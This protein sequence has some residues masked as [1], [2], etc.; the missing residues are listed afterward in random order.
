MAR[1]AHIGLRDGVAAG[2]VVAVIMTGVTSRAWAA[3]DVTDAVWS[4]ENNL[5]VYNL[6]IPSGLYPQQPLTEPGTYTNLYSV[7]TTTGLPYPSISISVQTPSLSGNEEIIAVPQAELDYYFKVVGPGRAAEV[8]FT[9][10]G[11]LTSPSPANTDLGAF[12]FVNSP[13][14]IAQINVSGDGA[15]YNSEPLPPGFDPNSFTL[16]GGIDAT[17]GQIYEVK[18][19]ANIIVEAFQQGPVVVNAYIDP[20]LFIDPNT[21]N[22]DQYSIV[23]SFGLATARERRP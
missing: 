8:D 10:K 1:I 5:G 12:L 23:T 11:S 2:V 6:G 22:A 17:T 15:T 18:I 13:N 20:Y 3:I 19:E 21:A 7:V 4:G 9:S 14:Y 16:Q